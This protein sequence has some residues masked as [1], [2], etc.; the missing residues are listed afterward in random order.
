MSS[1]PKESYV[2]RTE[3]AGE[4]S[5]TK[6]DAGEVV[7]TLIHLTDLHVVDVASPMRFEW[8]DT[9]AADP[10]WRPLLHMHRPHESLVPWAV[11]AQ[12]E[13]IHRQPAGPSRGRLAE[14]V[15]STGDNIDN[16]QRNELDAYLALLGGGVSRLNAVGGPQDASGWTGDRPWPFWSPD[17]RVADQWKGRG[18]P[19]VEDFLGRTVEPVA[20]PGVGVPWAS[21]PGNHDVMCQGTAL[22]NAELTKA[23]TGGRKGLF[24]PSDFRPPDPARLFVDSP[25]LFLGDGERAIEPDPGRRPLSIEEWLDA[26]VAA[27]ATGYDAGHVTARRTETVIELEQ[28]TVVMLDTNHPAGNYHGSIG[29]AQLAWLED[30]L[31]AVDRQPGRLAVIASHHGVESLTN[32]RGADADRHLAAA[33]VE[34][35]GRHRCV[36]AWLVGHRHIHRV[37]PHPGPAGGF[38]EITTGSLIDWPVERRTVEILRHRDGTI[39]LISTVADAGA[40]PDSLAGIHRSVAER[41][42]VSPVRTAMAGTPLDRDVRLYL[43]RR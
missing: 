35:V 37:V 22:L 43:G 23:L 21:L 40:T 27:G 5:G 14:L 28:L 6:A 19:V 11:A 18:Y 12:I 8:I 36:V 15:L 25:E 2:A 41:F 9:L 3:L 1:R 10:H 13:A 34:V 30:V 33:L 17:S 38:W 29:G 16:A 7:A 42:G 4:P 32:T 31:A 26:H 24:P 39:E 20:S